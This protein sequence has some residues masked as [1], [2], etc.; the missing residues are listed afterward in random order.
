MDG[1]KLCPIDFE[2]TESAE[3]R[4]RIFCAV[5]SWQGKE[6]RFWVLDDPKAQKRL[7]LR[8]QDLVDR[9]AVFLAFA[10]AAEA[11]CFLDLGVDPLKAQWVDLYAEFRLLANHL[12]KFRYG[13]QWLKGAAGW[14]LVKCYPEYRFPRMRNDAPEFNLLNA[15]QKFLPGVVVDPNRKDSARDL[16]LENWDEY[17]AEEAQ[18]ILDYCATDIVHLVPLYERMAEELRRAL[19]PEARKD[20]DAATLRRGAYSASCART[21]AFGIPVDL[22][23][24]R[25][26]SANFDAVKDEAIRTLVET[27]YPFFVQSRKTKA[28]P[29]VWVEKA[30]NF[31]AFIRG[32]DL[33]RGFPRT[34]SGSFSR[35]SKTLKDYSFLPEIDAL[36]RTKDF[37]KQISW[38]RPE[39]LPEFLESV[40][41]DGRLRVWFGQYGTQTGRNA[42]PAKRFIPAQSSWLRAVIRPPEGFA[43]IGADYSSQEF[44][45]AADLSGDR[46][47]VESYLSGDPYL[48]FGKLVKMIPPEGTKKTHP[49]ERQLCKGIIL[50]LQFGMGAQKLAISLSSTLKRKVP[51]SEAEGYI[52]KHRTAYSALWKFMDKVSR[53]YERRPI[54]LPDGW[55]MFQDNPAALSVRNFPVQGGGAC[56]LRR[57]VELCHADGLDIIFP[58]HDAIYIQAPEARVG[59]FTDR[60]KA[61]MAQACRDILGPGS[62]EIRVD[63]EIHLRDQVWV[64][65]KGESMFNTL[66]HHCGISAY[67]LKDGHWWRKTPR[68]KV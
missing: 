5:L 12:E 27:H 64:E 34:E 2:F 14:S 39:A 52:R 45:I 18:G 55:A 63:A 6:E 1:R 24:I 53:D 58:L 16:I 3:P 51:T 47:M 29:L 20:Q 30:E 21:E 11:R 49:M 50:G 13:E 8:L 61:A 19:P 38:Y 48:H 59:E 4:Q 41:S 46:N 25:T 32:K 60:L 43:I 42:P 35:E 10:S 68:G 28:S 37:I 44:A 9:G 31:E 33:H 56:I 57:A 40:G 67:R 7:A 22:D 54:V 62:L 36:R 23:P 17:S 15:L 65:E 66:R 26:L